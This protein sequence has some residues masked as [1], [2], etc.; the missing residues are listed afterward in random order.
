VATLF[1]ERRA[2]LREEEGER[3]RAQLT[4]PPGVK[5]QTRSLH[6]QHNE[7]WWMYM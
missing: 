4:V 1:L 2:L 3:K 7:V 6:W 5:V